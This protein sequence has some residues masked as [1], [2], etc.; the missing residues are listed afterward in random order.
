ME[1]IK[2][3]NSRGKKDSVCNE[4]QKAIGEINVNL[5]QS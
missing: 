4:K 1:D 2:S 5:E 3:L